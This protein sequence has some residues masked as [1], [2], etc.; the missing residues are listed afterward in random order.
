MAISRVIIRV[1]PF[2]ALIITLL[3]TYVLSTGLALHAA[4]RAGFHDAFEGR[5]TSFC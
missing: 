3:I 5:G 2:K 1:T 4:K